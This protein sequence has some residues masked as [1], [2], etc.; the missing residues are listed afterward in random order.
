MVDAAAQ[1]G[2]FAKHWLAV[3]AAASGALEVLWLIPD[4]QHARALALAVVYLVL[5]L[6][7]IGMPFPISTPPNAMVYGTGHVTVRD[8]LQIGLP[9]M[10]IGCVLV[11]L[12]G[13][14]FLGL[15]GIR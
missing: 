5:A 15:L 11:T 3:G 8:P 14:W 6:S 9:L 13:T 2:R 1:Q 10:I 4:P 12:S 7:E